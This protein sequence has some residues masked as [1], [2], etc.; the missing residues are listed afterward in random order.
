M[1]TVSIL[2]PGALGK[3]FI[4]AEYLPK[5]KDEY[6]LR[7]RQ[8]Q[9][10][11]DKWRNLR[12][13]EIEVLVKNGNTCED[14]D[15]FLVT[16]RFDA[17]RIKNSEFFG[18]VRISCLDSV[19]LRHHDLQMPAGITDSRI[20]SCDIGD[21]VA[22]HNVQ[23]LSHYIV[24]DR[25]MLLNIGEMH[26]TNHAKFGNGIIK[27]GED[28]A[29]RVTL[30]LINEAGGRSVLPFDGMIPA[31]AYLWAKIRDDAKLLKSL[32]NITQ[33]SFDERRGFYG[34]L[35]EQT[36]IKNSGIIKDVKTGACCYIKGANKLKNLTINSR[37]TEPTQIGEGVE[38][39][40][41]IIGY[42][43]KI[44]YGCKAVRFVMGNNA[45]LKYGA[46]LIHS[47]LG[48]N[49]TVSCCEILN[50]LIYPSHEQHHNN[51]FLIAAMVQG[52]SNIPAGATVGSNHSSRAADG[53]VMAG[54][55]FW[56]ALCTTLKHSCRFC[57]FVLVS[58]SDYPSELDIRL[59]FSLV[60]NDTAND[61]LAVMPAYWWMYNMYALTRNA[62][63]FE[64][65]DTRV[66]RVQHIEF[67]FLAPD[68]IEEIFTA[69]EML[70]SWA[71]KA[72]LAAEGK[73]EA[74]CTQSALRERGRRFLSTTHE[75]TAELVAG[76]ME[77]SERRNVVIKSVEGY[78]AYGQMLLYYSV[79]NCLAYLET[80]PE[81]TFASLCKDLAG[82]RQTEWVN[83][84]GQL[85]AGPDLQKVMAG[86][87]TGKLKTWDAIH[88]AYDKLWAAYPADKQRHAF[89]TLCAVLDT[90]KPTIEQWQK[91]LE[92]A[93]RI[94][95][96][97]SEQVYQSRKKDYENPFR[98]MTYRSQEEMHIVCGDPE[99]NSFVKQMRDQTVEFKKRVAA[100]KKRG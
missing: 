68:S 46:R 42:G 92:E 23:Y 60:S 18:L 24:G 69:R 20:I 64:N 21:N 54:R 50:S 19:V 5:G 15:D 7:D 65:R 57:S 52:Q 71:G 66:T 25:C 63:K 82:K 2:P 39:V 4:P 27:E 29:V 30:D 87:K 37:D 9:K 28:E 55:G 72:S 40:N 99:Q 45:N 59:P 12:A 83:I 95:E 79:K 44:F 90:A 62:W 33:K 77:H 100:V 35:G 75:S 78:Q 26:T 10:P 13:A 32:Q 70:E 47:F 51:S 73:T 3:N 17:T 34:V 6:Y 94:Q 74:E 58:K 48:D 98:Q 84:G 53:E 97:I 91:C 76:G 86:I 31:D 43:C 89:A 8:L 49:S 80:N 11:M 67:D 41:G 14:W 1:D 61:Q 93:I 56:P 88:E 96:Y 85:V 16:D 38:L 22:I 81:A 36:V